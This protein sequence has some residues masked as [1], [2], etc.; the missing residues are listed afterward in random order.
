MGIDLWIGLK[1]S[2]AFVVCVRDDCTGRADE[3]TSQQMQLVL[4]P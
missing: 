2:S 1:V 4:K 3:K